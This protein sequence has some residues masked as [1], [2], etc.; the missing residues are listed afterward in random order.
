ME[1]PAGLSRDD[2]ALVE[3][4]KHRVE[5]N[6]FVFRH[7]KKYTIFIDGGSPA[8]AYGVLGITSGLEEVVGPYLP[9]YVKAVLIPFEG[10][11]IYDGLLESYPIYFGGGYKYSLKE[12]YRDI[13]ERGGIIT[14]LPPDESSHRQTSE[15]SNKKVLA[16]FQKALGVSGLSS[17]M[18]QEHSSNLAAFA[19]EFLSKKIPPGM[20]LDLTQADI[21]AYRDMRKGDLNLV[22]FKRFVWFLRDTER[23]RWDE[24]DRLLRYFKGK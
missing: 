23:V 22:S 4:W 14:Q 7:L 9:I 20:L 1:N 15:A 8:R 19:S 13:Q 11:I 12:T 17:K 2:M 18:I 6:F 24:A 5:H 3:S 10:R 21:E 16:A